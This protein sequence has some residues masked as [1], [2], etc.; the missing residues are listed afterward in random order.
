MDLSAG[1]AL[2]IVGLWVMVVAVRL[3]IS[4]VGKAYLPLSL[5]WLNF[6][7]VYRVVLGSE[8]RWL[9]LSSYSTKYEAIEMRV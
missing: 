9:I 6:S 5:N 8:R 1:G 7:M 3:G 2:C 4:C